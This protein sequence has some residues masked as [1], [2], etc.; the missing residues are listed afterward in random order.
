MTELLLAFVIGIL[1]AA[2]MSASA[3]KDCDRDGKTR[4]GGATYV[5]ARSGT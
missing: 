1:G 2:A 3:S 5:C 4:L